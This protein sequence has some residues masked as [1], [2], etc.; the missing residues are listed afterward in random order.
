MPRLPTRSLLALGGDLGPGLHLVAG[1]HASG[2]TQ[3]LVQMAV[4]TAAA[5]TPAHLFL[6]DTHRTEAARRVAAVLSG[7][8]WVE[9]SDD[10]ATEHLDRLS[11]AP[12]ALDAQVPGFQLEGL[13][14]PRSGL[15]GVDLFAPA[16]SPQPLRALRH[17]ALAHGLTVV[18]TYPSR[19]VTAPEGPIGAA[20]GAGVDQEALAVVDSAWVIVPE[21]GAARTVCC[22]K[23]RWGASGSARLKFAG[24]RFEDEPKEMDL[25]LD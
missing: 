12:L 8:A 4:E 7:R 5:N 16:P 19:L 18:A 2:K 14:L 9:L 3:L 1:A 11:G 17:A 20:L 15:V 21:A 22:A 6:P 13:E 23:A 25:N 10:A 24:A